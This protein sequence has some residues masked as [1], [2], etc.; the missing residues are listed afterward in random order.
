MSKTIKTYQDLVEEK[1]KLEGLLK[2]QKELIRY[3]LQLLKTEFNP[4]FRSARLMGKLFTRDKKHSLLSNGAETVI[5]F[6]FK[7]VILN[8]AGWVAKLVVPFLMKNVSSHVVADNKDNWIRK[9]KSWIGRRNHN[10]KTAPP[11]DP[12]DIRKTPKP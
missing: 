1:E 7:K 10:G 11:V 4:V 3:D 8:K 6:M 12:A 5:D 2:A 9:L